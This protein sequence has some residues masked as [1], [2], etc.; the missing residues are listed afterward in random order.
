MIDVFVLNKCVIRKLMSPLRENIIY[1]RAAE[2][3]FSLQA[4]RSFAH[5]SLSH[6]LCFL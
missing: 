3:V 2:R 6:F 1:L 5:M 4:E